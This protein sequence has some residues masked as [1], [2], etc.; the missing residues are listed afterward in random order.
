MS[1]KR[2]TTV[3]KKND[4]TSKKAKAND[5][6]GEEKVKIFLKDFCKSLINNVINRLNIQYLI[7]IVAESKSSKCRISCK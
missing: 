6:N 2:K 7:A 5:D 4:T 3:A 1:N